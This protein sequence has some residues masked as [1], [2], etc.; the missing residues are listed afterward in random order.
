VHTTTSEVDVLRQENE[1]LR[2]QIELLRARAAATATTAT[3]EEPP[4]GRRG[5]LKLV[6]AAAVGATAVAVGGS[7]HQAAAATPD[8]LQ[9]GVA[10]Q[11]PSLY[12]QKT[13]M[14]NPSGTNLMPVMTHFDNYTSAVITLPTTH[15]IAL[16]ATVSGSDAAS[17]YRT[18]VYGKTTNPTAGGG[19]QGV[20][21]SHEGEDNPFATNFSFGVVGTTEAGGYAVFG[22]NP[23]G[24]NSTGVL[25]RADAGTGVIASSFTGV[26]L[27]VR[28]GGRMQ[29]QLRAAGAPTT[30]TFTA[31]EQI[32][33][34][35]ADLYICTAS[36]TPGTWRKVTA[37]HPAYAN[38]GGSVNLLA[39]PI[40]LLDT[41][42]GTTAPLNNGFVKVPGNTTLTLQITGTVADGLSVP[43][44]AKGI[45][46]N[47]TIIGPTGDGYAQVWPG[48]QPVP[49]TSNINYGA[50]NA[51][52]AL[53]NYFI[54]GLDGAGKLN[55]LTYQAA[56]VLVDVSGFVF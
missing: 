22:Y 18:A 42:P 36:G 7:A 43:A 16:A 51:A 55:V 29:Q 19:G 24:T 9:M 23:V 31:G 21:G 4:R 37:Q 27:L 2:E 52:P 49:S 17:G 45:L 10:S 34:G 54:S 56:H 13:R 41:R 6:G 32:R 8:P 53:A 11:A 3:A 35:N 1:A 5:F 30:G 50:V 28:D 26:S 47:L 33:D 15:R 44:G 12:T 20:F 46:G 40:R 38:S 39:K 14:F 25:G 48:G